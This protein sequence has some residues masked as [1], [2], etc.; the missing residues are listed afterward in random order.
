M[1]KTELYLLIAIILM[2]ILLLKDTTI[3]YFHYMKNLIIIIIAMLFHFHERSAT[4][5][6]R[7]HPKF[8]NVYQYCDKVF[9][10]ILNFINKTIKPMN[11]GNNLQMSLGSFIISLILLICLIL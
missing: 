1:K 6:D 3:S 8:K 4:H 11:V 10:P 7:L 5:K 2:A 9:S